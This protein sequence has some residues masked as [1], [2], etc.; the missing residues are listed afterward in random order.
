MKTHFN[1]MVKNEEIL[2]DFILP[3]W[4]LYPIDHFVFYDDNSEDNT[5]EIIKK[6][7]EP[8]R[9]T[10]LNDKLEK[11]NESHN[12]NRMLEFSREKCD[13][14][15][16]IDS[17][18]LLSQSILDNFREVLN[19][20][21]KI[22]LNMYWYNV[23]DSLDT[24]RFDPQYQGAFGRFITDTKNIG[25]V[26]EGA[27]YH[28]CTRF[29]P[30][31]LPTQYT[32]ELGVIHL[33]SLNRRYYAIKQLWYKHYENKFWGHSVNDI[34]KK[35]DPVINNFN[36][37]LKETPDTIKGNIK[38]EPNIFD[39]IIESKGYLEYILKN[40]NSDLI[41]FGKNYLNT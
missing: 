1:T 8:N 9:F 40:T 29:P 2:L 19:I 31:S 4:K 39:K 32:N 7:L 3:I 14:I 24:Y 18:E 11:F 28:T 10:I 25:I 15:F 35:Y 22:N 21:Q 36:F 6:H 37:N 17:D 5:I 27:K 30:S 16:Y 13:F 38:I 26:N 33:Q 34:N 23:V 12:R 20:H 41:T